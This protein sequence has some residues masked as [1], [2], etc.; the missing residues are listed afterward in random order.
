MED[1]PSFP[2]ADV[3]DDQLDEEGL[4]EKKK[5]KLLK[6]GFEARA[7]ARKEKEREKE[8]KEREEKK[9]EEERDADLGAWSRKMRQEQE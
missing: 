4:K 8:E 2:L 9:E 1:T 6:A 5:Q 7:R 3:P